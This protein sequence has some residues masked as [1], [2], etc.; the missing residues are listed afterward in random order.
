MSQG[1]TVKND[2]NTV[3]MSD[4][5]STLHFI[6][7]GTLATTVPPPAVKAYLTCAT[8]Y[9][10]NLGITLTF[11]IVYVS[12]PVGICSILRIYG[13]ATTGYKLDIAAKGN[14]TPPEV[15]IFAAK[16]A[17]SGVDKYGLKISKGDGTTAY[18]SRNGK[19]LNLKSTTPT[20]FPANSDPLT[21]V[22]VLERT[23]QE[24][25]DFMDYSNRYS[26]DVNAY[27]PVAIPTCVKPAISINTVAICNRTTTWQTFQAVYDMYFD[28]YRFQYYLALQQYVSYF[29]SAVYRGGFR[30]D[31]TSQ[32]SLCWVP[33][34][35]A[36]SFT[37]T[38]SFPNGLNTPWPTPPGTVEGGTGGTVAYANTSV[39]LTGGTLSIIDAAQYD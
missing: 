3:I 32:V 22:A 13:T 7:K 10:Y 20:V 34:T 1:F 28:G 31:S 6:G 30:L 15:Y 9:T 37:Y 38:T 21:L 24:Y 23:Y 17:Y 33:H 29:D 11:P 18:D 19:I 36:E 4:V 2:S 26:L 35:V 16:T 27:S 5:S 12:C 25:P 8:T 39:N 14:T